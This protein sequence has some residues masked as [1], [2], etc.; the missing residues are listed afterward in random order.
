MVAGLGDEIKAAAAKVLASK[1]HKHKAPT[2]T[3]KLNAL[4]DGLGLGTGKKLGG[5]ENAL[6]SVSSSSLINLDA[7]AQGNCAHLDHFKVLAARYANIG[8]DASKYNDMYNQSVNTP[9]YA[10]CQ[11]DLMNLSKLEALGGALGLN[12]H[13][14]LGGLLSGLDKVESTH[15]KNKQTGKQEQ[16]PVEED[17]HHKKSGSTDKLNALGGALDL[18]TKNKLGGLEGALKSVSKKELMNL[19]DLSAMANAMG[20]DGG[21]FSSF[22]NKLKEIEAIEHPHHHHDSY[23]YTQP[24]DN[25]RWESGSPQLSEGDKLAAAAEATGLEG[26]M[27]SDM[28]NKLRMMSNFGLVNL[29]KIG[30]QQNCQSGAKLINMS[31]NFTGSFSVA[32]PGGSST[33]VQLL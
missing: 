6:K 26:N 13:Q 16:A 9:R 31:N 23:Y 1:A 11:P 15:H 20:L 19:N 3:K 18:D 30:L 10:H 24:A 2:D 33:L 21:M 14:K 17:K 27:F 7:A 12:T 29:D 28:A 32:C 8:G 25:W 4:G 5:L 22:E